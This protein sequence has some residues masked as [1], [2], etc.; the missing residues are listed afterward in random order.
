LFDP[1]GSTSWHN[2]HL[3][4]FRQLN[5]L[6]AR[7]PL[8]SAPAISRCHTGWKFTVV[9]VGPGA[10]TRLMA[11]LLNDAARADRG[12]LRELI[13][14]AARYA[15]QVLRRIPILPL[16]SL[17]PIELR[18]ALTVR[19]CG[20]GILPV[21]SQPGAAVLQPGAAGPHYRLVVVDRSRRVLA[22]VARDLPDA[23]CHCVDITAA[24]VPA[25]GDVVVAFNIICRLDDPAAGMA[26]VAA[27]V[28]P[29]G[30]LLIDDRSAEAYLDAEFGFERV[31]AK[32]HRRRAAPSA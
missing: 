21:S 20:T 2:R 30:W 31:A 29:G 17:E 27:A 9:V 32:I 23:E 15:D 11:P 4:C 13:G 26:H 18:S 14:D 16:R 5:E 3:A 28:R 6:L 22:A 8:A 25:S 19:L 10:V 7:E 1:V 12:G 24:P